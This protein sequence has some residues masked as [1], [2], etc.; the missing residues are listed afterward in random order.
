MREGAKSFSAGQ[1]AA[2][3]YLEKLTSKDSRPATVFC[4]RE[5]ENGLVQ[6]VQKQVA[7][8]GR[9][10]SDTAMQSRARDIAKAD[11]TSAEDPALLGKFKDWM[12]K[13]LPHMGPA[14]EEPAVLPTNMDLNLSDEELGNIL[15]D[16]NFEFDPQDFNTDM[17]EAGG[18]SLGGFKH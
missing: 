8:T 3:S 12:R 5:L 2:N 1:F 15:Q 14:V 9:M 10:P 6:F 13:E 11:Y 18:V 16:M 4:S 17:D 7:D